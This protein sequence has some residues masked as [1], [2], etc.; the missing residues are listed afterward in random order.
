MARRG[1]WGMITHRLFLFLF[2]TVLVATGLAAEIFGLRVLIC[3]KLDDSFVK[4]LVVV[5]ATYIATSW[6]MALL[7]VHLLRLH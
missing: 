4:K 7:G 1:V 3:S 5:A 6:V 2:F